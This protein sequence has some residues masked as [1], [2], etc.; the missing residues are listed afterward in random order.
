M[1]VRGADQLNQRR[2][3]SNLPCTLQELSLTAYYHQNAREDAGCHNPHLLNGVDGLQQ[4][5]DFG[6]EHD[7][8]TAL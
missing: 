1:A 5:N 2:T 3:S 4:M 7:M 6:D 8:L